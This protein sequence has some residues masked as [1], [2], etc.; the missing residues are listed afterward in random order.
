MAPH[1]LA[2]SAAAACVVDEHMQHNTVG[3]R[4]PGVLL[5]MKFTQT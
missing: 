2:A 1:I 3:N 5:L 4:V